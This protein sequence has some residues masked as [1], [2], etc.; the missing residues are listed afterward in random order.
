MLFEYGR[1]IPVV[2]DSGHAY[3]IAPTNLFSIAFRTG[4]GQRFDR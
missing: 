2:H 3:W 1:M 4:V